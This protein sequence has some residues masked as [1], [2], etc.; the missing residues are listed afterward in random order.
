M[1]GFIQNIRKNIFPG[2]VVSLIALPLAL[3][4]ALASGAPPISG[5]ISAIVGGVL[6][7]VLGGSH[8]T[9]TGPG[10]GLVVVTLA[11]IS[12][13]G[14]GDAYQG[15]LYTLAA[16]IVSGGLLYLFGLLRLG[17]LSDLFPS[18][19]V[20]GMLAAIGLIIMAKQLH[21]MLGVSN[22][23]ASTTIGFYLALPDTIARVFSGNVPSP[24]IFTGLFA[25]GIMIFYSN[26]R[27]PLSFIPAPVWIVLIGIA[28]TLMSRHIID[29]EPLGKE[30]LI[31]IPD[32]IL[33]D[34]AHPDFARWQSGDF[35]GVVIALTL[36][37]TIES[38]L[39][40]KA[41]DKLDPLHRRSNVNKDLRALGLA[42]MASG[43]VGGLN[44]VT[45]IARSSVNV[46]NGARGRMSNFFHG[47]FLLLFILLLSHALN[48]LPLSALAAILVFTG[49]RL[50]EPAVF[51]RIAQVGKG[52]LLI[53]LI[54][55]F[56]TIFLGLISGIATGIVATLVLQFIVT[57]R[58]RLLVRYFFKPNTL[59]YREEGN[60]YHLSVKAYSNFIN[61][62]GVKRKLDSIPPD[63]SVIVDFSLSDF[64]DYSVMEQLHSYHQ[65]FRNGGGDLEIIGLDDLKSSS[66][67]PLAPKLPL[68]ANVTNRSELSRRQKALRLYSNKLHWRF[69][70][71]EF[72]VFP[73]FSRFQFFETRLIDRGR[74]RVQGSVGRVEVELA[75]IDYHEGEFIARE[76]RHSTMLVLTLPY[77]IPSFVMDKENLL[78]KVAHLAGF[79]DI[80]FAK[81]P[82]FSRTFKVK[83]RERVEIIHFLDDQLI[84]F[85]QSNKIYHL[86]SRDNA[87]LIFEKERIA[88][89]S[90]IKQIVSF[91]SRLAGILNT[92]HKSNAETE[93]ADRSEVGKRSREKH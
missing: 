73:K 12:T 74:N 52:Q 13:L 48:L 81:H 79:H 61:F 78:D 1:T 22:P 23:E 54:T 83:G 37:A 82:D 88:T 75:D 53:F 55:L 68:S 56:S 57:G 90:E 80:N 93:T 31:S 91:A 27:H 38:L 34:L 67:H 84:D 71:D 87:L 11:A 51:Q 8:V 66:A 42:T 86:E 89:L 76:R 7:S 50:A 70:A 60:I 20:Q 4:L 5:I 64:V 65:N 25:L 24:A 44:V 28:A 18:A 35:W 45:V 58:I 85:F 39:S 14:A 30:Y 40:I 59:L 41:V 63:S 33:T 69:D 47:L 72:F 29:I 21:V 3:G 6:V 32:N 2:F 62:I 49:Y 43:A 92:K 9:I 46:N 19:A 10:N 77:L 36:I 15:Y 16:I 17:F 26:V